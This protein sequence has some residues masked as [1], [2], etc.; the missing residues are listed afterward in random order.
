MFDEYLK[1]V[2]HTIFPT[3]TPETS[4]ITNF[5]QQQLNEIYSHFVKHKLYFHVIFL[6]NSHSKRRTHLLTGLG[7]GQLSICVALLVK[8]FEIVRIIC[9]I[10]SGCFF[11]VDSNDFLALTKILRHIN[12]GGLK[13]LCWK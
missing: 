5:R 1:A 4:K 12:L 3:F 6:I 11:S 7:R 10:N 2:V 13:F 8:T 9:K